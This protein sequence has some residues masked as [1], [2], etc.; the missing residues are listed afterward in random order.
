MAWTKPA[1]EDIRFGFE[2]TMY[3]ANRW[4]TPRSVALVFLC[5]ALES[6]GGSDSTDAG[7]SEKS[8]GIQRP[9]RIHIVGSAAGE[10]FPQWSCDCRDSDGGHYT[11]WT[12]ARTHK[13]LSRS[14][15]TVTCGFNF[16]ASPDV[17]TRSQPFRELQPTRWLR[18][19]ALAAILSDSQV[20]IRQGY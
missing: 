20:T 1:F 4:Y 18:D 9:R 16:N 13:H 11:R 12:P 2:I 5:V 15:V 6:W 10:R 17:L 8:P 19:A 3:I 7:W 14:P